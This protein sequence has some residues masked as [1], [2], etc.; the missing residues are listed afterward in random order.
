MNSNQNII[1]QLADTPLSNEQQNINSCSSI[2]DSLEK[3]DSQQQQQQDQ[4]NQS[5]QSSS[6]GFDYLS[7]CQ[8]KNI[9]QFFKQPNQQNIFL[10]YGDLLLETRKNYYDPDYTLQICN[11]Y[12]QKKRVTEVIYDKNAHLIEMKSENLFN[13]STDFKYVYE[14]L[15]RSQ[16]SQNYNLAQELSLYE[17]KI[18]EQR[19]NYERFFMENDQDLIYQA[20]QDFFQRMKQDFKQ[21]LIKNDHDFYSYLFYSY[22]DQLELGFPIQKEQGINEAVCALLGCDQ[23]QVVELMQRYGFIEHI[24][25]RG[26][27]KHLQDLEPFGHFF[28]LQNLDYFVKLTDVFDEQLT[29]M[30]VDGIHFNVRMVLKQ[31]SQLYKGMLITSF[32][33]SQYLVENEELERILSIRIQGSHIHSSQNILDLLL[34]QN[35]YSIYANKFG[36]YITNYKNFEPKINQDLYPEKTCKYRFV[37]NQNNS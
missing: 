5:T 27:P 22:I 13:G 19:I 18:V 11:T 29:I 2:Q 26:F 23:F 30:T 10:M 25:K 37:N 14:I 12:L 36:N 35:I 24:I 1:L 20:Q 4:N 33:Y 16:S 34:S 31:V 15:L 32:Y 7:I 8:V 21:K 28:M 17:Q 6:N 3:K 9:S